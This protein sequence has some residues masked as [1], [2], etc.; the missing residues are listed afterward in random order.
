MK[1]IVLNHLILTCTN[2]V[3]PVPAIPIHITQIGLLPQLVPGALPVVFA[4]P[5]DTLLASAIIT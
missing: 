1:S 5:D 2:V 4:A 3:L